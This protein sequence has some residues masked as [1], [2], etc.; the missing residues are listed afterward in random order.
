MNKNP[1]NYVKNK[2]SEILILL[3]VTVLLKSELLIALFY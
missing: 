3:F 2:P 1:L